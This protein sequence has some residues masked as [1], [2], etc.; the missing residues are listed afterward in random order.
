MK[1]M[2]TQKISVDKN[3][4]EIYS[5]SSIL[6]CSVDTQLISDHREKLTEFFYMGKKGFF[7]KLC[8]MEVGVPGID[9]ELKELNWHRIP[10]LP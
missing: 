1:R 7:C 4:S 6:K 5:G 10:F 3:L 9:P 8:G 2:I